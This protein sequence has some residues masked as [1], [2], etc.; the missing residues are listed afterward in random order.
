MS[1]I[2][3]SR[4]KS[5]PLLRTA[6]SWC[7]P[8]VT[9]GSLHS[10]AGP[11]GL[12]VSAPACSPLTTRCGRTKG[13]RSLTPQHR[14]SEALCFWLLKSP[15]PSEPSHSKKPPVSATLR[16]YEDKIVKTTSGE[17]TAPKEKRKVHPAQPSPTVETCQV[18]SISD[19]A[20]QVL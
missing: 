16:T 4:G 17:H 7:Y 8:R 15:C 10:S 18:R 9:L 1:P 12:G 6:G 13:C 19:K 20:S 2:G 14:Y 11:P 5:H 3:L